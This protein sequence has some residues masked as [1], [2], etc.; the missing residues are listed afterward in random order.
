MNFKEKIMLKA[1]ICILVKNINT[2][3][4]TILIIFCLRDPL[5]EKNTPKMLF[6]KI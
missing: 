5:K 4:Q 6:E 2:S 1:V 3:K